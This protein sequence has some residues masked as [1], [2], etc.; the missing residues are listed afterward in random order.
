[1]PSANPK[2]TRPLLA[3]RP[4]ADQNRWLRD[5][6]AKRGLRIGEFLVHLIECQREKEAGRD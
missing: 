6:A 3:F 4:P 2:N 5:Q 1:M